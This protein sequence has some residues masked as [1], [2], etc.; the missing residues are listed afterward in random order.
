VCV[1]VPEIRLPATREALDELEEL[2]GEG[3]VR[4]GGQWAPERGEGNRWRRKAPQP[5]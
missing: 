3:G 5:A 1:E 2:V 4:L